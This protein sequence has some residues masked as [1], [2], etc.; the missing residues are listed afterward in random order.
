[1][2]N[3]RK[4]FKCVV[5][6]IEQEFE[7]LYTFKSLK[8]KKDYLIYTDNTYDETNNL[9][10]YSSIYYPQYPEKEIEN[11]ENEDDWNEV[12]KFL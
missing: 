6:G 11:I 12:E 2:E 4:V 7:I 8:T 1:M 9:N 5:N 10:I 3:D